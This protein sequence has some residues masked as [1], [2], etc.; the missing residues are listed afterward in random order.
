MTVRSKLL[1]GA[2]CFTG[3][4]LVMFSVF[5]PGQGVDTVA[6]DRL[7]KIGFG[8]MFIAISLTLIVRYRRKGV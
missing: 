3:F 2:V 1:L 4:A 5:A 7:G 6:G 8:V